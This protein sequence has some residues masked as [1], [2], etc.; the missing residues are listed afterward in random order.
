MNHDTDQLE[1]RV[2]SELPELAAHAVV[3]PDAWSRIEE[4]A[5]RRRWKPVLVPVAAAATVIVLVV[6]VMAI[7]RAGDEQTVVDEPN[8]APFT[9]EATHL[10]PGFERT[11]YE[12]ESHLVCTRVAVR[13]QE[14]LCDEMIG[15]ST[16]GYH[17]APPD[18]VELFISVGLGTDA[19]DAAWTERLLDD[20][21]G[22]VEELRQAQLASGATFEEI[23]DF[24]RVSV[25]GDSDALLIVGDT[26]AEILWREAPGVLGS[27]DASSHGER[28]SV[29]ELLGIAEDLRV[30]PIDGSEFPLLVARG[31]FSVEDVATE[32]E[33]EQ[34]GAA[35][36]GSLPL[37]WFLVAKERDGRWCTLLDRGIP[38]QGSCEGTGFSSPQ[39][40]SQN[41]FQVGEKR[42]FVYGTVPEATATVELLREGRTTEINPVDVP[43]GEALPVRFYLGDIRD[44]QFP[45]TV[46]ALDADGNEL[47]RVNVSPTPAPASD[48]P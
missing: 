6:A 7:L 10:P 33:A 3:S 30:V 31:T 40:V 36:A 41:T 45:E 2:R 28:M 1:A 44:F 35:P 8:V 38:P 21:E 15:G 32:Q 17:G 39:G 37:E 11:P 4:Q 18:D 48:A 27:V 5:A 23:P 20:P 13:G 12:D 43:G 14:T 47:G 46:V 16:I 26:D 9:F 22:A 25:R 24:E 19:P 42:G 34:L 29:D